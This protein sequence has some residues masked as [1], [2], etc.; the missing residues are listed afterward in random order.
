MNESRHYSFEVVKVFQLSTEL[1]EVDN[2]IL[3]D[4]IRTALKLYDYH[5]LKN[6]IKDV[7]K[8]MPRVSDPLQRDLMRVMCGKITSLNSTVLF[9]SDSK[10]VRFK[11][12]NVHNCI[13]DALAALNVLS[14]RQVKPNGKFT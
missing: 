11:I 12:E 5:D 7:M 2:T 3:I 10:G 4:I 6:R 9:E 14:H 1:T 8:A 13:N